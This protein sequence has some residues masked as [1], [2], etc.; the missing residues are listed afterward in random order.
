MKKFFKAIGV[1]LL[2]V[3]VLLL[4]IP[5]EMNVERSLYI[6]SD[7]KT[8]FDQVN[9]L[10]NWEAWSP[11]LQMDP[12]MKLTYGSTVGVGAQYS[13]ESDNQNV[14]VGSLQIVESLPEKSLKTKIEFEGQGGGNGLWTFKKINNGTNVTW[15]MQSD[16]PWYNIPGKIFSFLIDGMVGPTFETGLASIKE[17]CESIAEK[18]QLVVEDY[19]V[20]EEI[21]L[22]TIKDSGAYD[23]R[24]TTKMELFKELRGY[25]AGEKIEV[26]GNPIIL[27]NSWADTSKSVLEYGLPVAKSVKVDS[28]Y[29]VR[30]IFPGKSLKA[31]HYGKHENLG[32]THEFFSEY[33]D[34]HHVHVFG[35]PWEIF[36]EK[37]MSESDMAK[38]VTEVYYPI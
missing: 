33:L 23:Q 38:W 31:I 4:I 26:A 20:P 18:G 3:I 29:Q 36:D 28:K 15:A 37:S 25:L 24:K 34:N 1:V 12:D 30:R 16:I 17:I 8:V 32:A 35:T 21:W 27:Y 9:N 11:W 19:D 22:V 5:R 2:V 7:P 14:G 10:K 13:W 6:N